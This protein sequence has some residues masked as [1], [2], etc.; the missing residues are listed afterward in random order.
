[1]KIESCGQIM[2]KKF[3]LRAK[4]YSYLNDN[5]EEDK[6]AKSTKNYVIKTKLKF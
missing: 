3:G 2:K 6:K 1:M 5:N 4:V